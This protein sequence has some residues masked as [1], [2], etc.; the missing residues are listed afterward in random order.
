M[1][2]LIGLAGH[3]ICCRKAFKDLIPRSFGST[4]SKDRQGLAGEWRCEKTASTGLWAPC[5]P[6]VIV[7]VVC[8]LLRQSKGPLRCL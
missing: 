2:S 4:A 7:S 3:H 8:R 6:A 5:I 1:L